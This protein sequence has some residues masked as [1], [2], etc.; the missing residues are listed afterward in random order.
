MQMKG[1][2]VDSGYMGWI[3]GRYQLFS[4]EADYRDQIEEDENEQPET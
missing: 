4:S 3:N 2:N 1:Y